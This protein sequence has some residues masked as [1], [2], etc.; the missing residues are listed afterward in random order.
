MNYVKEIN[1]NNGSI[2]CSYYVVCEFCCMCK[3]N[4]S[5]VTQH[6]K[7]QSS[8]EGIYTRRRKSNDL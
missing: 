3:C 1:K 4:V 5:S 8:A 7:K 6:N 2:Q